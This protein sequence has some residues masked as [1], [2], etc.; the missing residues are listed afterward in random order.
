[1]YVTFR[2]NQRQR[3]LSV[4]RDKGGKIRDEMVEPS[5]S[6]YVHTGPVDPSLSPRWRASISDPQETIVG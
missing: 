5:K 3:L 2:T 1:M 6:F 4:G